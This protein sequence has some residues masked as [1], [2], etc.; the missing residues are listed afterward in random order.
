MDLVLKLRE[1]RRLRGLSQ[2]EAALSSGMSEKTLS[3]FET[4]ER[5]TSMKLAQ[6]LALLSAYD[7]TAAEFFGG[8]VEAD[9]FGELERLS[10]SEL[11]LVR[12]LRALPERVRIRVEEKLA[13]V[14]ETALAL[15]APVPLRAVR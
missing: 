15:S 13:D 12:E 1:L 10:A 3:S 8:K 4:G 5:I 9:V 14:I 7:I 6:L 11:G 2:K